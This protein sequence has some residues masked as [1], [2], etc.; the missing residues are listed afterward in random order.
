MVN[1]SD[2]YNVGCTN[3]YLASE[4]VDPNRRTGEG[5][6]ALFYVKTCHIGRLLVEHGAQ[7]N[8]KDNLQREC[9]HYACFAGVTDWIRYLKEQGASLLVPIFWKAFVR[10]NTTHC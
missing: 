9:I 1:R 2:Y 5:K 4:G 10:R 8:I 6:T 7:I 3:L